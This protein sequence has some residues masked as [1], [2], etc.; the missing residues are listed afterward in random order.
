L[1]LLRCDHFVFGSGGFCRYQ[2][3]DVCDGGSVRS[4]VS[5][6]PFPKVSYNRLM[7]LCIAAMNIR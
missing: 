7:P 4:S 6:P 3:R 5:A 2:L 1:L